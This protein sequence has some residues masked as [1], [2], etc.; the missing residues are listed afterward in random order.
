MTATATIFDVFCVHAATGTDTAVNE[1]LS[2]LAGNEVVRLSSI[3][4]SVADFVKSIPQAA[5]AIDTARGDP[6]DLYLTTDTAG[7]LDRAIWPGNGST[8]TVRSGQTQPLGVA[9][10]VNRVQN[11]S[12]WDYDSVSRDDL[13]G[14][15]RIDEGE[16]GAGP[17][18]KLARNDTEGSAYY[19]TYQVD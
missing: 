11:L 12:L 7:G 2:A 19:V 15:I 8:G 3:G 1:A 13:L 16:R 18:A 4:G 17:I 9:V 10:P 6:D 5:A 14:S